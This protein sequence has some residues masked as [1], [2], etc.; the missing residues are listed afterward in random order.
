MTA[1]CPHSLSVFKLYVVRKAEFVAVKMKIRVRGTLEKEGK[2][3]G[4]RE[5]DGRKITTLEP[6]LFQSK[7]VWIFFP[8]FFLFFF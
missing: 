7:E 2:G 4:R 8:F 1:S 6:N 5:E 3:R